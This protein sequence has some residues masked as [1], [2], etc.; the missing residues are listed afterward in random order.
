MMWAVRFGHCGRTLTVP[1]A[2][3]LFLVGHN[4]HTA[5]RR[6]AFP[7]DYYWDSQTLLEHEMQDKVI[8]I[9]E[10]L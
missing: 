10:K 6:Y 5:R 8:D 4:T 2:A 9:R 3:L 1:A 7:N